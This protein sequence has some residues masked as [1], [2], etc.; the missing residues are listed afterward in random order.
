MAGYIEDRWLNKRPNPETGK[1]ERTA[2]WGKGKRY[3]V[4]GIP[5]VRDRSFKGL[6]DAKKWQREAATDSTRGNL[7]D[8]R[9]GEITLREYVEKHWWPNLRQPPGTRES[10]R[11]R[12]FN[13]ILP[14]LGSLPLLS[15]GDEQIRA[16]VVQAE[17]RIDVSTVRTTWK[18]FSAIMQAAFKAKRIPENPFRDPELKAPKATPSKAKAWPLARVLAV[19]DALPARYRVLVDL[20]LGAGLRQ[21][22]A[23]GF[24]PDDIVGQEIHVTRQVLK[25]GGQLAFGPP[26]GNKTRITVCPPG[27]AESVH[28]HAEQF[29]SLEVTLPWVDPERPNLEWSE[30]PLRTARLLVTTTHVNGKSGGAVNRTTWDEKAWKPALVKAGVMPAPVREQVQG[31]KVVW[32]R[33]V[34]AMDRSDGFHVLRHT[35]ASVVLQAGETITILAAWLGHSDPAFTLRTYV[36]FLPEAGRQALAVLGRWLGPEAREGVPELPV[37]GSGGE[38]PSSLPAGRQEPAADDVP[39]GGGV[40]VGV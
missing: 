1:R 5:G 21:G 30:R 36:H 2:L 18:H 17:K 7:Y 16:W 6:E 34:W 23:F 37:A 31:A 38:T 33:T 29:P 28:A 40:L 3:K 9:N 12:V 32:T 39:A 19:R 4:A 24:S 26:K 14:Y 35:F 10:M 13:H 20:A 22:E 27:L 8:P 11:P 25:I 15:I